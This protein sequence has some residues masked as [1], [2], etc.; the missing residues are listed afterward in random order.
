MGVGGREAGAVIQVWVVISVLG[1][2]RKDT[3]TGK[4]SEVW[5]FIIYRAIESNEIIKTGEGGKYQGLSSCLIFWCFVI[6][7]RY[8]CMV[9]LMSLSS[10]AKKSL[11]FD[12]LLFFCI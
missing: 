5:A 2:A 10:S 6:Y 4:C 7:C 12:L 3:S 8:C 9:L 11:E 1:V